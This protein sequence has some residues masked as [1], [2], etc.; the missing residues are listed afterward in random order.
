M[1]RF[2]IVIIGCGCINLCAQALTGG[3]DNH[4][5]FDDVFSRIAAGRDVN[6]EGI[7]CTCV[8]DSMFEGERR[9][10]FRFRGDKVWIYDRF[11]PTGGKISINVDG[12]FIRT[13]ALDSK[14]TLFKALFDGRNDLH[15]IVLEV[16]GKDYDNRVFK[17]SKIVVSGALLES[18]KYAI[19][20]LTGKVKGFKLLDDAPEG[21]WTDLDKTENLVL[22][23]IDDNLWLGIYELTERQYELV[24][25]RPARTNAN[26]I[27]WL[28]Y[29]DLRGAGNDWPLDAEPSAVS[30]IG[31]LRNLTGLSGFDLPTQAEW[32]KACRAG[33]TTAYSSGEN[34]DKAFSAM[35]VWGNAHNDL[36]KGEEPHLYA[37]GT[38]A[39][40]QWGLYDMYGNLSEWCL[41]RLGLRSPLGVKRPVKGGHWHSFSPAQMTSDWVEAQYGWYANDRTGARI[42]YREPIRRCVRRLSVKNVKELMA[43]RERL[44]CMRQSGTITPRDDVVITL[45]PG[46]YLMNH[47]LSLDVE[48]GV[49]NGAKVVFRAEKPHTVRFVG[50]KKLRAGDFLALS[51]KTIE[52]NKFK[53][54][55]LDRIL[56]LDLKPYCGALAAWPDCL[57]A[58]PGPWL[59]VNGRP[60]TLARWPNEGWLH[61]THTYVTGVEA[62]KSPIGG[63]AIR[64]EGSADQAKAWNF[65]DGVWCYGYWHFGWRE[66]FLRLAS[67]SD[68]EDGLRMN[69][70]ATPEYG[71][72]PDKDIARSYDKPHYY[73][74][75]QSRELDVPNEFWID[76][77]AQKLYYVP[78]EDF[79]S[80]EI[81]L[82]ISTQ[83][84]MIV[85]AS[86]VV[87]ENIDFSYSHAIGGVCRMRGD[88]LV[89]R[90]CDF[91]CHGGADGTATLSV[92][93]RGN[94]ISS[95]RVKYVG[96]KGIFIGGGD[97]VT[98]SRGD[99]IVDGCE[100]SEYARFARTY[101]SG[102]EIVGVGNVIRNCSIHDAPHLAIKYSG[103]DLLVTSNEITRVL[104]ESDDSGAVYD[105]RITTHLGNVFSFNYFH[106]FAREEKVFGKHAI[107]FDDN[108]WGG[109]VVS[110]RFERVGSCVF[111][112]GGGGRRV[113]GNVFVDCMKG[114]YIGGPLHR[115]YG[116]GHFA[117]GA[118]PVGWYEKPLRAVN[119]LSDPW[120]TRFPFLSAYFAEC[121]FMPIDVLVEGN[122]FKGV[123]VPFDYPDCAK[124][125]LEHNHSI[126]TNVISP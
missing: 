10:R 18:E 97:G 7:D 25:G 92:V 94:L 50:G 113:V 80:A 31:K 1:L 95:C 124:V 21:G 13:V 5:G 24:T 118:N 36:Q 61:F 125:W 37:V 48:D 106:D 67:V 100:V 120:K 63:G 46:D 54:N 119:Y 8:R 101:Q 84:M 12:K 56:V 121:A 27:G 115:E 66:E 16:H 34:A 112:N 90:N 22:R 29:E 70:S 99:S 89:V 30:F 93:G 117:P 110:N 83:P 123:K 104:L 35:T 79:S 59:Y 33:T 86:G 68:V 15:E 88:G 105:G 60:G 39:P 71:F 11:W 102:I 55:Y 69:F 65:E 14:R 122:V 26:P 108:M 42:A 53:E 19:I 87:L 78:P 64:W 20:D 74:V 62:D 6:I 98:L 72:K 114:I 40:N 52:R 107:Y 77:A 23:R 57:K 73:V 28:S 82:A 109:D 111:M 3:V 81:F 96:A 38:F 103:V 32:E 91:T 47:P 58:P 44:R 45:A 4:V 75:N 41:D 49:T 116:I 76:R 126:R 9:L 51:G 43:I 17:S 85:A 2:I